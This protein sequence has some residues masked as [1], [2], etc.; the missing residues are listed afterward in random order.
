MQRP[1]QNDNLY[2]LALETSGAMGSVALG[3][4]EDVL[5]ARSF[6]APLRHA[7]EFLPTVEALCRTYDARPEDIGRV[8]VSIGPGSFTG[9]RIGVT[10]ARMIAFAG[11]QYAHSSH[12]RQ[13]ARPADSPDQ[14][15]PMPS[16]ADAPVTLVPVPT[17][18]VIAQN[19]FAL[20][21]PPPHLVVML[22]AKRKRVYGAAFERK[23]SRYVATSEPAE[24]DPASF[25]SGQPRNCGVIGEGVHQHRPVVEASG[26]DI[27]PDSLY[28]PGAETVYR[29]GLE[30]AKAGHLVHS[31]DLVPLYIRPPEAEE[32]WQARHQ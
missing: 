17:L 8:Y 25:L 9:L 18:D 13:P 31:R 14:H 2:D 32:K 21:D 16:A 11:R 12:A 30:L 15:G 27:L 28:T 4:G 29:L 5:D 24:L 20:A 7:I 23:G 3:R 19:A 10:A 22:D 1:T 6:S 26:L